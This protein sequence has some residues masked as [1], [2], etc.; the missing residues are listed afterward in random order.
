MCRAMTALYARVRELAEKATKGPWVFHS[1][2][3]GW[4]I[5]PKN[6]GKGR[7][8]AVCGQT[9]DYDPLW[10]QEPSTDD[11][12]FIALCRTAAPDLAE[13]VEMAR[14]ALAHAKYVGGP[15]FSKLNREID[16]TL[17]LIDKPTD[18]RSKP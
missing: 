10:S 12:A 17:A 18:V 6:L 5:G 14:K 3:N 1:L 7:E 15:E 9:A 2:K 13:Q 16:A 11:A 8:R 4:A